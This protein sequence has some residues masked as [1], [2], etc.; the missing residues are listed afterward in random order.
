MQ[1][2]MKRKT[3]HRNHRSSTDTSSSSQAHGF[4]YAVP[5]A[6]NTLLLALHR[7]GS[8]LSL[9]SSLVFLLL[10]DNFLQCPINSSSIRFLSITPHYFFPQLYSYQPVVI[11]LFILFLLLSNISSWPCLLLSRH[12]LYMF[13]LNK[14]NKW[15]NIKQGGEE[16]QHLFQFFYMWWETL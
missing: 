6:S 8:L 9:A 12:W 7:A 1:K 16:L 2:N 3:N 15:L 4:A 14:K 5:L 11:Y 13:W 10:R